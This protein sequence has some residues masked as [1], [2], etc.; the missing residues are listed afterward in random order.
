[1]LACGESSVVSQTWLIE[2]LAGAGAGEDLVQLLRGDFDVLAGIYCKFLV[3][4]VDDKIK[5]VLFIYLAVCLWVLH[6]FL[7]QT[8]TLTQ[9]DRLILDSP[10]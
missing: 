3:K 5:Q 1:M 6:I 4:A 9:C 8:L 10:L 7:K 2:V